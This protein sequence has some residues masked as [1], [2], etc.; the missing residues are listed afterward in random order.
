MNKLQDAENIYKE[1]KEEKGFEDSYWLNK[2][3][4]ELYKK[5]QGVADEYLINALKRIDDK[6][7]NNTQ[8]D[9][10]RFGGVVTKLGYG[11]WFLNILEKN[12]FNT[13]LAPYYVAIKAITE[14]DGEGFLNSKAVEIREPARK[15]MEIMKKY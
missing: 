14:K 7:P 13:I 10:W 9:W 3:L 12:E 8:D 4:F 5:N 15:I 1:L 6:L 2:T 11:N